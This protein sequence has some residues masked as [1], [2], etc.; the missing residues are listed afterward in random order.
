MKRTDNRYDIAEGLKRARRHYNEDKSKELRITQEALAER[1][2]VSLKTV[3]NWEQGQAIPSVETLMKLAEIYNC[4]LDY[5]TG[6]LDLKTHDL[7]FIHDQTGL[8]EGAIQKLKNIIADPEYDKLA[9]LFRKDGIPE[10]IITAQI[11]KTRVRYEN[12][13]IREYPHIISLLL[14]DINAEYL[15]SLITR[16]VRDYPPRKNKGQLTDKEYTEWITRNDYKIELDGQ[17]IFIQKRNL[18]DSLIQSEVASM[19]PMITETY[20]SSKSEP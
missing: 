10:D 17:T 1:L 20:H 2:G 12:S 7:Q 14:E 3:M 13:I 5:L 6:R 4:D 11:E 19:I 18:L 9:E 8:S 15:L 16:R